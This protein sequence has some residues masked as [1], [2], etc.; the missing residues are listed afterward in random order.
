MKMLNCL[1]Y[2][3]II[4]KI[5]LIHK[6]SFSYSLNLIIREICNFEEQQNP[7]NFSDF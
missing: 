6:S 2:F 1:L 3:T 7:I 5:I 4:I